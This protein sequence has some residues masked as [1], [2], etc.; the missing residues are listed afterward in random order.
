MLIKPV[1]RIL[2]LAVLG[3]TLAACGGDGTTTTATTATGSSTLVGIVYDA[4]SNSLAVADSD[5]HVIRT[6]GIATGVT[7]VPAGIAFTAGSAD[8]TGTAAQFNFPYGVARIG[9]DTYIADTGNNIIRKM[10]ATGVVT[11]IAGTAKVTGY[12]DGTGAA[13]SFVNPK[14]ITTDGTDLYVADSN[15]DTIRKVTLAGVVTTVAGF[16][17]QLG[18]LDATGT[19]ARF[20]NPFGLTVDSG[21]LYVTDSLNNAVR[22]VVL[23]TGVVSTL[24]GSSA[25]TQGSTDGTTG[26]TTTFAG[27]SG[28][29]VYNGY[30]YVTDAVN[31]TI[32]KID[33]ST[34]ATSTLAG[35]AG[36]TGFVDATGTAARFGKAYGIC[37]DGQGNLYVADSGNKKIRKI[38]IATGTVTSLAPQF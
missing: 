34:G 32:R 5:G 16:P 36:V 9:T 7:G 11:T 31:F 13:A 10:S 38:E 8:G 14:G 17:G 18:F 1:F 20:Y 28:I 27:P 22:K 2:G 15:N 30:A 3:A 19:A 25:G 29:A 12:A 6:V 33:L 26:A 37:S 4:S 24:A 23:A 35:G 21:N